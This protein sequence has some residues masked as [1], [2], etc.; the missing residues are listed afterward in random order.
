MKTLIILAFAF[1]MSAPMAGTLK[2]TVNWDKGKWTCVADNSEARD[3]KIKSVYFEGDKRRNGK[4]RKSA[5]I[6]QS[7]G[8]GQ[9]ITAEKRGMDQVSHVRNCAFKY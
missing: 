8:V 3:V 9:T 6:D 4:V 7:V 2:G 5:K 1:I